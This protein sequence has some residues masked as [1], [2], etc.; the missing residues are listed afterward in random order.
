M[1]HPFRQ[2]LVSFLVPF[3]DTLGNFFT[4]MVIEELKESDTN[5]ASKFDEKC[6]LGRDLKAQ[7]QIAKAAPSECQKEA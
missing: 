7:I 5:N 4:K 3:G 1:E 6:F 2:L